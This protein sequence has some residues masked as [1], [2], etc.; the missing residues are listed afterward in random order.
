MFVLLTDVLWHLLYAT[1]ASVL[2]LKYL[3][4]ME[5]SGESGVGVIIVFGYFIVLAIISVIIHWLNSLTFFSTD[6]AN[7]H[8]YIKKKKLIFLVQNVLLFGVLIALAL[9]RFANGYS[10]TLPWVVY[11]VAFSAISF[12]VYSNAVNR[13]AIRCKLD[14]FPRLPFPSKPPKESR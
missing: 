7:L 2:L 3:Q 5:L 10:R 8:L 1:L 4:S 6:N 12:Y 11:F 9:I 14:V 13:L